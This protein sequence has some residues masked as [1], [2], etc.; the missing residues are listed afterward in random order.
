MDGGKR[1]LLFI[2]FA[3]CGCSLIMAT[4]MARCRLWVV[5][6]RWL[7]SM[8]INLCMKLLKR[9]ALLMAICRSECYFIGMHNAM[10]MA[11]SKWLFFNWLNLMTYAEM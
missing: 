11:G 2:L 7:M 5:R 8:V 3:S 6:R 1:W 4:L 10:M 9:M